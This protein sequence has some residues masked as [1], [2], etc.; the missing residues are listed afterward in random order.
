M[1]KKETFWK[2]VTIVSPIYFI[3]YTY[4]GAFDWS[5]LFW[6]AVLFL[7]GIFNGWPD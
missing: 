7:A 1:G 5:M 6:S 3:V 2:A 4:F